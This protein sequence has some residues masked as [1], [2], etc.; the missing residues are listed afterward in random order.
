[1]NRAKAGAGMRLAALILIFLSESI[2]HTPPISQTTQTAPQKQ[3]VPNSGSSWPPSLSAPGKPAPHY[4]NGRWEWDGFYPNGFPGK[5]HTD[6]QVQNDIISICIEARPNVCNQGLMFMGRYYGKSTFQTVSTQQLSKIADTVRIDDPDHLTFT[7]L[8][9]KARKANPTVDDVPCDTANSYHITVEYAAERGGQA[10][11]A[12]DYAKA[13]CWMKIAASMGDND[14]V[15]VLAMLLFNDDYGFKQYKE[16]FYWAQKS[17][18]GGSYVGEELMGKAYEEGKGVTKDDQ[19]AK[20]W[21]DKAQ[22]DIEREQREEAAAAAEEED[23]ER[24]ERARQRY[25]ECLDNHTEWECTRLKPHRR[26][27]TD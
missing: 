23:Q 8:N 18:A 12:K 17:A 25:A 20:F 19:K 7:T 16:A 2:A 9:I 5:F 6:I 10:F 24:L 4:L 15:S 13:K 3:A 14:A 1:M 21:L 22:K 27:P 11:N 26:G